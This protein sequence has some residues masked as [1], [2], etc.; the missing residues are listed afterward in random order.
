MVDWRELVRQRMSGLALDASEKEEV[1][2]ELASHLEESFETLRTEGLS[3]REAVRRALAQVPDWP[4]LQEKIVFARKDGCFMQKRLQ[5]LWIPGFLT[6]I[7]SM[8]FLTVLY[9]LGFEPS[10]FWSGAKPT[11]LY[12]PWLLSLP[13][14]G[15]LGAYLSSRAGG[16][17]GT[18][19]LVSGFPVLALATAFLLMIPIS[20]IAELFAGSRVNF[21]IA[22]ATYLLKDGVGWLLLP[23]AAFLA[24]SLLAQLFFSGRLGPRSVVSH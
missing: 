21:D 14:L 11:L 24:G 12:V 17:R 20:M 7:L 8:F 4:D 2:A 16:S 1:Q 13:P 10:I 5:Q 19:F 9:R 3:E 6:L 15:A 22:L 23:G 18:L